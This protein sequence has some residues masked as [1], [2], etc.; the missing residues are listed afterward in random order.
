MKT[1]SPSLEKIGFTTGLITSVVLIGYFMIMKLLG[2]AHILE[3]RFF[4]GIILAIGV[5]YGI[6]KYNRELN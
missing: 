6:Y 3:L 4:N 1:T 5:C 2:F